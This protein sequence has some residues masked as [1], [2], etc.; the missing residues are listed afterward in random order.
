[1][2]VRGAAIVQKMRPIS[3]KHLFGR[4]RFAW[5]R[6]P[7]YGFYVNA[8]TIGRF[9][10][11]D[12]ARVWDSGSIDNG[13]CTSAQTGRPPMIHQTMF[14]K[15]V[16][17]TNGAGAELLGQRSQPSEEAFRNGKNPSTVS[18]LNLG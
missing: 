4:L 13:A 12:A 10:Y 6:I 11:V 5:R 1:M 15:N 2:N 18:E 3:G 8:L 16:A 9:G 7:S 14:P 17:D